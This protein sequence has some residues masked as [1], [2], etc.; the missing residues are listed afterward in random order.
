MIM[1]NSPR[2]ETK[3]VYIDEMR[4]RRC[5]GTCDVLIGKGKTIPRIMSPRVARLLDH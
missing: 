3:I 4:K 2:G 5:V 1:G